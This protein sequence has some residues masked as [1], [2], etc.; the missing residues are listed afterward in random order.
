MR[1]SQSITKFLSHRFAP[2]FSQSAHEEAVTY[3]KK[4][5]CKEL[6]VKSEENFSKNQEID[7]KVTK[8]PQNITL[9]PSTITV[10]TYD[11]EPKASQHSLKKPYSMIPSTSNSNRPIQV[12][13]SLK[14][15][16][17]EN[18]VANLRK[19]WIRD[20]MTLHKH[21]SALESGSLT[22]MATKPADAS[23]SREA[24]SLTPEKPPKP[25]RIR[26]TAYNDSQT[27]TLETNL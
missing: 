14:T 11:A 25:G 5:D 1:I 24:R 2:E 9:P 3:D 16:K 13:A 19:A 26:V 8:L 27:S 18:K 23:E 12:G 6:A 4:F 17:R 21:P 22:N 20:N 10:E 7:G 15:E